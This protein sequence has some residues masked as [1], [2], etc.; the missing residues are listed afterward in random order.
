MTAMKE[1]LLPIRFNFWEWLGALGDMGTFVP[2]YLALVALNGM[3]PARSLILVG[4]VYIGSSLYF[5]LPIPVQPLK[6]MGA[7]A[8]ANGL[9]MPMLAAAGLW[10]G[11]LL[12]GLAFTGRIEWLSRYFTQPIIKG[13][14]LGIGLMLVK[15]GLKLIASGPPHVVSTGLP[16]SP[17][18][19]FGAIS[20]LW[21]LVLPQLPLTLGNAVFA[22]SDVAHAYFSEKAHRATPT[23]LS[24]SL[25][26]AN[27]MMGALGGLPVCHGSGGL[28]AHYRFGAR[29]AG[30]TIIMGGFYVVLAL[31]FAGHAHKI[32]GSIP[33]A[34]LGAMVI[35]VGICHALLLRGLKEKRLLAGI[36]GGIGLVTGNLAY[37]LG[38]G[39]IAEQACRRF[40]G[41]RSIERN[42]SEV[43]AASLESEAAGGKYRG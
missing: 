9:G 27:L 23:S 16:A 22:V 2:I 13:I 12:L 6:A 3:P 8:I 24:I 26:L 40:G 31:A 4:M 14:Q 21:L 43:P 15:V 7:I 25:G 36:V 33:A 17:L 20:V 32:L 42:P 34:L 19:L 18:N 29:T 35:Y 39:L 41:R 28:T 30:S 37:A 11:V 5:R 10:M 1:D 38:F